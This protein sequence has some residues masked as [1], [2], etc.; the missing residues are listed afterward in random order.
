MMHEDT[1]ALIHN[2][3]LGIEEHNSPSLVILDIKLVCN[4]TMEL[5]T[6]REAS[7]KG[8]GLKNTWWNYKTIPNM[9]MKTEKYGSHYQRL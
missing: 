1:N 7:E 5:E 4:S 6:R 9:H 8:Y 3:F 2:C